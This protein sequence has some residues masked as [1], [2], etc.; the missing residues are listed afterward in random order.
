MAN[1]PPKLN[2]KGDPNKYLSDKGSQRKV[3]FIACQE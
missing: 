2:P 1:C 3:M